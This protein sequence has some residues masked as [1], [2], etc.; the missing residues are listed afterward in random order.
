MIAS[1][2]Q[3]LAPPDLI[4]PKLSKWTR[5]RFSWLF[6]RLVLIMR[7]TVCRMVL[8]LDLLKGQDTIQNPRELVRSCQMALASIQGSWDPVQSFGAIWQP[9]GRLRKF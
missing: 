5:A 4:V 3:V 9:V 7:W 1:H 6:V 2:L 8:K